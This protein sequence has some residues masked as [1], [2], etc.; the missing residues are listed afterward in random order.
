[1]IMKTSN[2]AAWLTLLL[3]P[4]A[5]SPGC[6]NTPAKSASSEQATPKTFATPGEAADAL[7]QAA[8]DYDV[9]TLL[10]IL[11]PAG[12]D[13]VAAD[14]VMDK[15]RAVAFA[16]KAR[17][18]KQVVIDPEDPGSATLVVGED[19]WPLPIPIEESDGRWAFDAAEGR[20]EMLRRRVGE[21]ELDAITV[22]R[23][24]VEAQQEYAASIH[25]RSGVNQFA[26]RIISTPGKQD[27]LA[28]QNPDGS[29]GGPVG[30]TA[31]KA[32]AQGHDRG[33]AFHGYYY[34]VLN[35][36]GRS[37]RLG[38]LDYVVEGVMIGGFAL[39]AW[40]AQYRVTGVQ[41]F[42]VSYD[43]VVYQ[44]DLGPET[45]KVAASIDRYDPDESWKR[46]DDDW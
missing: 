24:Y 28:W 5:F 1:M 40:P 17:A 29:W 9:P 10:A 45:T 22:C 44:K 32:I 46:T 7:V 2:A 26:Q 37:A 25:D 30:E 8:A 16:A 35:G 20:D 6:A 34:R 18:K 31:A 33:D 38:Q 41:T 21:N 3:A 14:P 39:L 23:G 36:Q 4:V 12:K 19:D 15:G 27:G 11:G 42:M 13:L 43:G